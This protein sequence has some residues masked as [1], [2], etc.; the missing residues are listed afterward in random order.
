MQI[1]AHADPMCAGTLRSMGF[2][3]LDSF[4]GCA[5][6]W[7]RLEGPATALVLTTQLATDAGEVYVTGQLPSDDAFSFTLRTAGL[8]LRTLIP[9][10]P[11]IHVAG[12]GTV[13]IVDDPDDPARAVLAG[14]A[15]VRTAPGEAVDIPSIARQATRAAILMSRLSAEKR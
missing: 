14:I 12:S 2:P 7:G 1:V 9:V 4:A 10:A 11:D 5:R 6:G 3:G 8:D 15:A 13:R